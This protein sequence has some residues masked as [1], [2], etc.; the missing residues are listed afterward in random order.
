MYWRPQIWRPVENLSSCGNTLCQPSVLLASVFRV[1]QSDVPAGDNVE[2]ANIVFE[3]CSHRLFAE[4]E[5]TTLCPQHNGPNTLRIASH[6]DNW[7]MQGSV[8][9]YWGTN[10]IPYQPFL[11]IQL[12]IILLHY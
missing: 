1:H 4:S 11:S 6:W 7:I 9:C 2:S 12:I 3:N 8:R 10:M 5:Q